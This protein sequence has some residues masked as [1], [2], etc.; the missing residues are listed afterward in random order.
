MRNESRVT[1]PKKVQNKLWAYLKA[2]SYSWLQ[3]TLELFGILCFLLSVVDL[4]DIHYSEPILLRSV[5]GIILLL[6]FAICN[7]IAFSRL[8][9]TK[10]QLEAKLQQSGPKVIPLAVPIE[11]GEH[12]KLKMG[13]QNIGDTMALN[14]R[15]IFKCGGWVF[16]DDRD[17]IA[18][19]EGTITF[20]LNRNS[21]GEMSDKLEAIRSKFEEEAKEG[22]Q[23]ECWVLIEYK[24]IRQNHYQTI[25]RCEVIGENWNVLYTG[26]AIP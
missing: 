24:D 7:F 13:M 21:Y 22:K 3:K 8:I 5:G 2:I 11:T 19:E 20:E 18:R 17:C 16:S 1:I 12:P 9:D 14:L 23:D 26:L 4:P 15:Y 6:S 25:A 10:R